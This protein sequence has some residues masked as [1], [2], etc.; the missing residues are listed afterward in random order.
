MTRKARAGLAG[1][2]RRLLDE[3]GARLAPGATGRYE[4]VTTAG[5]AK[6]G[7]SEA[8]VKALA[9]K[10]LLREAESGQ[11]AAAPVVASW[12]RRQAGGQLAFR[13]QHHAMETVAADHP[14]GGQV[15]KNLEESAIAAL[16]RRAGKNGEPWLPAHAVAAAE[17]LRRDFEVGQLQPRITANWSAS[18]ASGRRS[19]DNA[20]LTD[21]TEAALAARIRFERAMD[22]IGPEFSGLVADLC[23]FLKGL[24]VVERERQWPARSAKLVLRL[25]LE[26][27]ARHYGLQPSGIGRTQSG[28]IRSWGAPDYRPE[29]S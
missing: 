1:L 12:L 4:L 14:E 19:G 20:G 26:A 24:E 13:S 25:A 28:G 23:C 27:L 2:M 21:L 11:F 17:R 18:V 9:A 16:A 3:P 15:L 22:A 29:I 6:S 10:G 8:A 5:R 7:L